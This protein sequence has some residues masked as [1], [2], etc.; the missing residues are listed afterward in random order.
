M[1]KKNGGS[2]WFFVGVLILILLASFL[3]DS[4]TSQEKLTY[5]T[6]LTHFR[7]GMV[8][9]FVIEG[10]NLSYTLKEDPDHPV[11][12]KNELKKEFKL[13][14][15]ELFILD[16]GD[17]IAEQFENKTIEKYDIMPEAGIPWWQSILPYVIILVIMG[18][19]FYVMFNQMGGAGTGKA[20]SFTKARTK[21]NADDKNRVTFDDVAGA[22]EEKEE[23]AEI[24]EF[25]KNPQKF[26][27]LGARIPKGIILVGPPGNGKTL[28]APVIVS[29][30][31]VAR[32]TAQM[33]APG[34]CFSSGVRDSLKT[35]YSAYFTAGEKFFAN[36]D[37]Y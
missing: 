20:A 32:D 28:F 18:G 26:T 3:F 8:N 25:L 14:S 5:S 21:T 17:T 35:N 12:N 24:V 9:D 15:V 36:Y 29:K 27:E 1:K 13:Y 10:N 33:T 16:A 4:G 11:K 2:I 22:E 6:V 19:I 7:E 31:G 37:A 34:D 30:I 23:L